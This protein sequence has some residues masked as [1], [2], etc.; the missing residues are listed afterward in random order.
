MS[1][2]LRFGKTLL[3]PL[4]E[5][6]IAELLKEK[7]CFSAIARQVN[8]ST[9]TVCRR[10]KQL[11]PELDYLI[12]SYLGSNRK[13]TSNGGL[14]GNRNGNFKRGWKYTAKGYKMVLTPDW[15]TMAMCLSIRSTT[16]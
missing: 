2:S 4:Q 15:Y 13:S 7:V 1:Q 11:L 14:K 10:A 16:V 12:L 6:Q 8:C 3:T 5:R 9:R